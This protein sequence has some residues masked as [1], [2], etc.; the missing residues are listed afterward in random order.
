MAKAKRSVRLLI[1]LAALV[2]LVGAYLVVKSI[3]KPHTAAPNTSVNVASIKQ[4][5]IS[6]IEIKHGSNVV[7]INHKGS[8]FEP[9]TP[10]P[11]KIDTAAVQRVL[12]NVTSVYAQA[13]IDA[14][15]PS[16]SMLAAFGLA[17]PTDVTTVYLKD[18]KTVAFS[19][20]AQTPA[21]NGYYF[22]KSGDPKVYSLD[23]YSAQSMMLSLTQLRDHSLPSINAQKLT[24]LRIMNGKQDIVIQAPPA[25]F[26]TEEATFS[27]MVMT[28]PFAGIHAVAT[29]K[30]NAFLKGL[31]A[32]TIDKFVNDH[33]TN[34]AQYGLSPAREQFVMKDDKNTL[35]ILFGNKAPS[36]GYYA[37][38]AG[39]PGV[40]TINDS[41]S[42]LNTTA[43]DLVDKFA[44]IV[45]IAKVH[46][47][48]LVTPSK[49]YVGVLT[50]T[51]SGKSKKTT[52]TFDGKTVKDTYFKNFYQVAIGVLYDAV[53]P[54]PKPGNPEVSFSLM[55]NTAGHPTLTADYV[56]FNQNF[57][58]VYRHGRSE[59]VVS[60]S[61]IQGIINAAKLLAEGKNPIPS[62][63]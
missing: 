28:S 5:D 8:S 4:A 37:K 21:K 52:Y 42:F 59:F 44:L 30:L 29:N 22:Q 55:L 11:M 7:V 35:D 34:L 6:K 53:N 54:S 63:G 40:F 46:E 16:A 25:G 14:K 33:P 51:G 18:G 17:H 32:F 61:Q 39:S 50:T 60:R 41:L 38:L 57:Y 12:F 15:A 36:G 31:P 58:Q 56:P 26:K 2:V 13:V 47:L 24:Y 43:F 9:V 3:P 49:T 48:K 23:T 45:N 10:Y 27:N 1:A 19:I 20:G 62:N